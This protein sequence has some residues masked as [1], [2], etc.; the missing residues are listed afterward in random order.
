MASALEA[1]LSAGFS[2]GTCNGSIA[3][4]SLACEACPCAASLAVYIRGRFANLM[5]GTS[6]PA[7]RLIALRVAGARKP[8][9]PCL[10]A[11]ANGR[12]SLIDIL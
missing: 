1:Y 11:D 3:I 8:L 7:A 9:L 2:T 5:F 4:E 6:L 12:L 10:A